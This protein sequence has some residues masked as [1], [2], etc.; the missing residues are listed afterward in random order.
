MPPGNN[1][2][3]KKSNV[4]FVCTGNICRS[5]MAEYLFRNRLPPHAPFEAASAGLAAANGLG[6]S[7]DA[8][9]AMDEIGINIRGHASRA[10]TGG[11]VDRAA[12]IV[13]MTASQA[14][15]L[16]R[17]F[18]KTRDRVHLLGDFGRKPG[19]RD[20]ADPIGSGPDTYRRTLKD[21]DACLE[22]LIRFLQSLQSNKPQ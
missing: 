18:P 1:M 17:H 13:V 21:I 9:N 20:I 12:I 14:A 3:D 2:T 19:N 16:K 4:L 5:P 22:G 10:L 6:P 7:R 15:E 8:V 11:L